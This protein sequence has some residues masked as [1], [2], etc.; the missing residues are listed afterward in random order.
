MLFTIQF[1]FTDLRN[2]LEADTGNL[3]RPNWPAPIPDEDFVRNFGAIKQRPRGGLRGIG[4]NSICEARRSLI[5]QKSPTC[6]LPKQNKS[7]P[8][9]AVFKRF[10]FDGIASGYIN[11][12]L[13]TQITDFSSL[14]Y[15][16]TRTLF[17]NLLNSQVWIRQKE[18]SRKLYAL[19]QASKPL[20]ELYKYSSVYNYSV[21]YQEK[22]WVK[23][24][25]PQ[26][27]VIF[28]EKENIKIHSRIENLIQS[29]SFTLSAN[30]YQL[31]D[32]KIKF[33]FIKVRK[34]TKEREK[35]IRTLRICLS[36]L[37]SEYTSLLHVLQF[38]G[39]ER[40]QMTSRS[41]PSQHLQLYLNRTIKYIYDNESN[42]NNYFD[43]DA[44]VLARRILYAS[45]PSAIDDISNTLENSIIR[46][47]KL[48][49]RLN[50]L[51]KTNDF[52]T[53]D[54]IPIV[55]YNIN[56][57]K[58]GINYMGDN[59]VNYGQAGS[60]GRN[61]K[62]N[63]FNQNWESVSNNIDL[64][65]LSNELSILK[66]KLQNK[67]YDIDD[68]SDIEAIKSAELEAKKGNGAKVLEY[69]SQTGEW[70]LNIAKELGLKLAVEVINNS[71]GNK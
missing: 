3:N 57:N 40:L 60:M 47:E 53:N 39:S 15:K 17:Y 59:I 64:P 22:W 36:R 1:P 45:N 31:S 41:I 56:I 46:L 43:N 68:N 70:V 35:K 10:S 25:T 50:I 19:C 2:F 66:S 11:L 4:E 12:G 61:S 13:A 32:K 37:Y 54:I 21:E 69:L 27:I 48:N 18:G 28:H 63:N 62:A 14:T 8:F 65:S 34:H 67:A 20:S 9:K 6:Y 55:K 52:I 51:R 16:E 5:L 7:I 30:N 49:I 26:V 29:N 33:W 23:P 58:G 44:V 38:I 71:I 24:Y 42:I